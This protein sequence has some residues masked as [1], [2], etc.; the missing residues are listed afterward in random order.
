MGAS[1]ADQ[2]GEYSKVSNA[3]NEVVGWRLAMEETV[4]M[5]KGL[6]KYDGNEGVED[7]DWW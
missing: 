2:R 7:R 3:I 5:V 4:G 1:K 6:I